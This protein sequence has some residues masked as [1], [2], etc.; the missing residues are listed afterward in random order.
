MG[1]YINLVESIVAKKEA[2][3]MRFQKSPGKDMVN[4]LSSDNRLRRLFRD[5]IE[6]TRDD[7]GSISFPLFVELV[8]IIADAIDD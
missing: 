7:K 6:K 4:L 5:F 8:A 3:R 1:K 2:S